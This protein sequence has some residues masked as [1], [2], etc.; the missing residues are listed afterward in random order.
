VRLIAEHEVLFRDYEVL[1]GHHKEWLR[2]YDARS[3][4]SAQFQGDCQLLK[5]EPLLSPR[6][7]SNKR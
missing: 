1:I 7:E 3:R 4:A 2:D 6:V 5:G